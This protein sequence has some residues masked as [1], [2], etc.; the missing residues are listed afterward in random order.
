MIPESGS[1]WSYV[2]VGLGNVPAFFCSWT[3]MVR[4]CTT[5]A[6]LSL[7]A[8]RHLLTPFIEQDCAEQVKSENQIFDQPEQVGCIGI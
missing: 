6:L 3:Y 1:S 4:A 7:V 2:R 5:M 8:A